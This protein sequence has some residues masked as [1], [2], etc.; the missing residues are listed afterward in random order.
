MAVAAGAAASR[1]WPAGGR[2][3]AALM[4]AVPA[5]GACDRRGAGGD[6]APAPDGRQAGER[7]RQCRR[8]PRDH[9]QPGH[10]HRDHRP[11]RGSLDGGRTVAT[12]RPAMPRKIVVIPTTGRY[13]TLVAC[14]SRKRARNTAGVGSTAVT[15]VVPEGRRLLRIEARNA[16]DP[17]RAQA[18]VDQGQGD[19]WARSS[20]SCAA[21]CSARVCTRCA[22][23]PAAPTSTSAGRTGRPPSSSAATSAPGAATSAR[24][25]PAGRP[26]ST[27]TNRAGWPSRSPPWACATRPITGVARDD[28]PDGGAWLY[29]ETVRQIHAAAPRLR[30]RAAH[31]RLQRRRRAA[32]RGVR[33]RARGAGAQPG[34]GAADLQA[35]PARR[36]ATTA[37]ST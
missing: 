34:D 1:R 21:W 20:P 33:R 26:S 27:P 3:V 6:R 36:S 23:R 35:D 29:A 13:V 14:G 7:H 22:R 24:S 28:L 10:P 32:G 25:T 2:L 9:D 8:P 19:A 30:R 4:A 16:R 31:P 11:L 17:D 15:T 37:R 18:A 5:D 12:P